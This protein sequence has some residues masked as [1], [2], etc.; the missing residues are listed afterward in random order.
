MRAII[1]SDLFRNFLGGFLLG[2]VALFALQPQDS[3]AE[4]RS[5]VVALYSNIQKGLG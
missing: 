3:R 1:M 5:D 2:A 4:I